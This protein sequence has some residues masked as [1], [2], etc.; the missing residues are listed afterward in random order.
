L[1]ETPR[2]ISITYIYFVLRRLLR[3]NL[4]FSPPDDKRPIDPGKLDVDDDLFP[5]ARILGSFG[6]AAEN[7]YLV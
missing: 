5:T 6:H 4:R 2:I 3:Q 1:S 7:R